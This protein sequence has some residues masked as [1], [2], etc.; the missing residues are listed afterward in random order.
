ML[1][2]IGYNDSISDFPVTSVE[3]RSPSSPEICRHIEQVFGGKVTYIGRGF[4]NAHHAI[5]DIPGLPDLVLRRVLAPVEALTARLWREY[6]MLEHLA[7]HNYPHAPRPVCQVPHGVIDNSPGFAMT[8]V[9]GESPQFDTATVHQLGKVVARLH[10]IPVPAWLE[11]AGTTT[12]PHA[13]LLNIWRNWQRNLNVVETMPLE[14]R[15]QVLSLIKNIPTYLDRVNWSDYQKTL[16]HGDLGD[17]NFVR[18]GTEIVLLDWEFGAV[19]DPTLDVMWLFSREGF[20]INEQNT[21]LYGYAEEAGKSIPRSWLQRLPLLRTIA[22]VELAIWAQSG[23][24]DI[25][26]GRNSH[27]FAPEDLNFLQH[28]VARISEAHPKMPK[29]EVK[30][31]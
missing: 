21:F 26:E 28:Q 20:G 27:F 30:A 19:S 2:I 11:R 13:L 17:H 6:R 14:Y 25:A 16:L 4:N 9:V 1:P 10:Q 24:N 29:L 12:E 23:V 3:M 31:L 8:R 18:Q 5:S 22:L 15:R 7:E